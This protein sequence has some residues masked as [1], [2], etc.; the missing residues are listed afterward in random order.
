[1]TQRRENLQFSKTSMFES[2]ELI[3]ERL[4]G[5][6]QANKEKEEEANR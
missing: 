6:N 3:A 4:A 1:M 2:I 5:I